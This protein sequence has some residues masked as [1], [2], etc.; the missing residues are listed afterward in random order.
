LENSNNIYL[1][2]EQ[3]IKKYYTNEL[4][5]GSIFFIGI[6]LLYFLFTLSI[7]YFFWLK[8]NSRTLL[9]WTFVAVELF[10][11]FRFILFPISKLF[12]LQNGINYDDAS[13]IIG[14]HFSEVGDKLTNF[15]QLSQDS[16]S[17]ELL[18]ASIDQKA[19]TLQPIPFVKAINFSK[20][21]KYAPIA[22]IPLLFFAFFYITGYSNFISQ[23]LNRVVH[24]KQ[25]F[26]PPAPFEFQVVNPNLQ[27]EQNQDFVLKV[28][29]VGK[30]VPENT[31]I[32]IGEESYFMETTKPG[33]FQFVI[34]K[35]KANLEFHLEAN[36]VVSNDYELNVVTVPTIANFEMVLNFPS[37]LNKKPEV[38][39][40]TGNA[41]VPEG[42]KVTWRMNTVATQKVEWQNEAVK[43]SFS[44]SE[45]QFSLS[46]SI[47]QNINYQIVTS[48]TKI[49]NYEKLNYQITVVKDQFP[50]I[51]VGNAPDSLKIDKSYLLG[52]VSDDYGLSK[53]QVIYYPKDK[54]LS[55]KKATIA[56]KRDVYDQFVFAFPSNLPVEEGVSYEYYFEIF[57]ND[58]F[59]NYK[60]TKSSVFSNR[61][62]TQSEKEDQ[63]LQQQNDNINSMEKSLKTQDKQLN[64]MEKLQKMGKEKDNLEFKEQQ[65]VEDF[66]NKQKQQDELMKNF[67]EKMKENL[68]KVKTE[69]KDE[70]K[71]LLKDRLDKVEKDLE[72]NNKLLEELQKLNEKL[73]KEE[74]F[75]K[76]D[77]L[78]QQSKNQTKSLQQLVEL[79]KK[80]YVEKKAE[81]IADKLDKLSEKQD[82]LA[83]DDKE[84]SAEKQNEINKEFD[85]IQ[86]EL[87]ELDKDNKELKTPVELPNTDDKEKSIDEDLKKASDQL[88][89]K[90]KEGAKPKQ[91]SASK[92]MK[93]MSQD[94]QSSM[95]M[96]EQEQMEEDVAML[97]QILDNLLAYS[98]SQESVMGQ[99]KGLKRG[100]PSFNKNLKIQQDLKQEF[101]HVDDSLFALSLRNP[102]LSEGVTTEVG[103]VQYNIEKSLETLAEA[104][105]FKGVSYQ[106]FAISSANKLADMLASILFNMQMSM[107]MS[108]S[109]KG[110]GMPSP[111]KG[112]GGESQLPDIIKK[113]G[114]L[115]KKMKDGMKPGNKPGDKPGQKPGDKPGD[116]PGEGKEGGK[117]GKG[118]QGKEG[119]SGSGGSNQGNS[120]GEN[121]QDGEGDAKAIMEIYKEQQQLRES[122]QKELEKQGVGNQGK[123]ALEQMKQIEK[124]L[125][126][127]GFNNEVLQKILNVKYELLKLEKAVQQQ[128]EEKKRQS[129]TSKK[130][131]INTSTA[132]PLRL[133]EYINSVEILNR[134]TLPLRSNYNQKVQEYFNK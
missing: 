98:F 22:L 20:N 5:R 117:D 12:K 28:K 78:K 85:K 56:V 89:K 72:K 52:Q 35:P 81:Q 49:Q 9:F 113:Q 7:E 38:I 123:S 126:N 91:K 54:P 132:L 51:S 58:A 21:K 131:F 130:E 124:Q 133:Q 70:V 33:E 106:Q 68:D 2:L 50:A 107:Q 111:G 14:N 40:G 53:L 118:K 127:K 101:K 63:L 13:K 24:Y 43:Y 37:Y 71:E 39:K 48:N 97:R 17:S 3:F 99:F 73:Q 23:S 95:E 115:E 47:V 1:K 105:V 60:S 19:K 34:A 66:L 87:K 16:N 114:D 18:L 134:Q 94:M 102:K 79:T 119:K 36:A 129:E 110:K 25:Q 122:L 26:L 83:A 121:G 104:D 90:S 10:L 45:N 67:A 29:T 125:L 57:D 128:G 44:K 31:M 61:I 55:A 75:D 69:K 32:F 112:S 109:G 11:L 93:Q 64:E 86:E 77:K 30:V 59:H 103:N 6:G 116:K 27:T 46:K 84:N 41:V 74:L 76:M 82:K 96:G 4:L 8:P 80:Y 15:L 62:A 92:K 108:G 42:T 100:S 120:D 88:Q 65:K